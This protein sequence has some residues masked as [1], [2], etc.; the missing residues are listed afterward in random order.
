[1]TGAKDSGRKAIGILFIKRKAES[2]PL[3]TELT[4]LRRLGSESIKDYIIRTERANRL[5]IRDRQDFAV[6]VSF[7]N[8]V[9]RETRDR[10]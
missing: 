8:P 2:F 5:D 4:S 1:M 6:A 3:Y 10:S 9:E 7:R